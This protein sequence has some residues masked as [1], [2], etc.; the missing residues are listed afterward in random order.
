[1]IVDRGERKVIRKLATNASARFSE[2]GYS[3]IVKRAEEDDELTEIL[4][5]RVDLPIKFLRDLLRRA[6]A[7]VRA[8]LA[9]IASPAL[10]EEIKRVLKSILGEESTRSAAVAGFQP[11]RAPRHADE[12]IERTA[13]TRP[14]SPSPKPKNSTR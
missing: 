7:A 1:M 13:T 12:A 10:R 3:G 6:T 8:R 11:R 4:G 14:S 9:A 2:A 5:L